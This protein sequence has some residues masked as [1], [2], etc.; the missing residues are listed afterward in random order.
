MTQP[1]W[2]VVYV[3]LIVDLLTSRNLKRRFRADAGAGGCP[4]LS[5]SLI[6]T[7][8]IK[9]KVPEIIFIFW[10]LY[11]KEANIARISEAVTI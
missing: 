7:G 4:P 8:T 3:W 11:S 10:V 5:Y 9:F 2:A 1:F 6:S